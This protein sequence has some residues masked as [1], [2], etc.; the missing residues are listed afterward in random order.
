MKSCGALR[1]IRFATH[2]LYVA[3]K[4]KEIYYIERAKNFP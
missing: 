3:Q 4:L 2:K 1:S